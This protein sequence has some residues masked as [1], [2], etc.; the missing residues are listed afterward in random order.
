MANSL[1][2]TISKLRDFGDLEALEV[3][4]RRKNAL[5]PVIEQALKFQYSIL[6]RLLVAS[7]TGLDLDDLSPAEERI[8]EATAKYVGLQKREGK[9]ANRTFQMLANRGLIESAE[10]SVSK[11]KPSQGFEVLEDA[12]LKVLSFEQ[13]IVDFPEEFSPR[14]LWFARKTL[15]LANDSEKPPASDK[16][17]TQSR[18]EK[19]MAC[20]QQRL[21]EKAGVLAGHTN[22]DVGIILGFSDLTKHGRV[23]GNITS[24][25][26]FACYKVG[27]PPLGLTATQPFSNA[28]KQQNRSWA[29][30][31][32]SMAQ[33]AQRRHWTKIDLEKVLAM[34][35]ELPGQAS[36]PWQKEISEREQ[37]VREWA[38]A[39]VSTEG[40]AQVPVISTPLVSEITKIAELERKAI[41]NTPEVKLKTGLVI[42]RGPIGT[43]VKKANGFK[44]QI[45][46]AMGL[47]PHSFI[48]SNGLPYVEAHHV[49]PVSELQIGSLAASNIISV[50]ANHHRQLHYGNVNVEILETEFAIRI[51]QTEITI[52]RSSDF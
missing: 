12:D 52:K 36:I 47:P 23:L 43:A 37:A 50:C 32:R 42:E 8:V 13:I 30:P 48:K 51:N 27:L 16:L 15:E 28:W 21:A 19:L 41:N 31:V 34:V 35:S 39:L 46:E 2:E 20:Y 49:M 33:C 6:G 11:T 14:A 44:C 7:R 18:T 4:I 25:I 5:T 10:I 17:I 3:N 26:D 40:I 9:S 24:R 38:F 1:F 45:C 29:Y 22:A